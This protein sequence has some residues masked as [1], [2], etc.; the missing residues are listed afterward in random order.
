[1]KMKERERRNDEC[2]N[3]VTMM[4]RKTTTRKSMRKRTRITTFL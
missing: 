2:D 3:E 4:R 1:M